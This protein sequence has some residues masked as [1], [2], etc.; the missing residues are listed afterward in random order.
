MFPSFYF[1]DGLQFHARPLP[2]VP[3]ESQPPPPQSQNVDDCMTGCIDQ[4]TQFH[5]QRLISSSQ[6]NLLMCL[7][8]TVQPFQTNESDPNIFVVLY[9]FKSGGENQLTIRKG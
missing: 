9:D 8:P 6:E 2:D 3:T 7:D 5:Q 4:Q 1:L